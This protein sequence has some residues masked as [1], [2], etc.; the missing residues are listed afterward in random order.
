[1]KKACTPQRQ[2]DRFPPLLLS[3]SASLFTGPPLSFVFLS[4]FISRTFNPSLLSLPLHFLSLS[5]ATISFTPLFH[6]HPVLPFSYF[7]L[8]LPV[9]FSFTLS[10]FSF[11]GSNSGKGVGSGDRRVRACVCVCILFV[12]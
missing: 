3:C 9:L 5:L 7:S 10:S 4:L 12:F 11:M 1:M 2:L 6:S 8:C